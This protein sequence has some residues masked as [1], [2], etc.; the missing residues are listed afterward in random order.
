MKLLMVAPE[1]PPDV[2]GMEI[3]AGKTAEI[4]ASRGHEVQVFSRHLPGAGPP[5]PGVRVERVLTRDFRASLR[6]IRAG[7]GEL[8]PA[9][10]LL[11]NAGFAPLA[12]AA[13][14]QPPILVRT[15]GNDAYAAWH[16]PRLPLRF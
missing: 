10:V 12:E 14:P 2:G 5:P 8:R 15:A 1:F 11:M 3:H 9:A 7:I 13:A 4:L 6:A 16:G